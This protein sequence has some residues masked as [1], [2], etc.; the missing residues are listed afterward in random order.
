MNFA[1]G[2]GPKQQKKPY[3]LGQFVTVYGGDG[4]PTGTPNPPAVPYSPVQGTMNVSGQTWAGGIVGAAVP[5]LNLNVNGNG[6]TDISF[7]CSPGSSESIQDLQNAGYT[8]NAD[9]FFTGTANVFLQG[10]ASRMWDPD[11]YPSNLWNTISGASGTI[12]GGNASISVS[13]TGTPWPIY[14]AYRIVASGA[15]ATGILNWSIAGMFT[16]YSAMRIGF[17]AGDANGNI[18]QIS[19][20]NPTNYTVQSGQ[21]NDNDTVASGTWEYAGTNVP[22]SQTKNSA[23]YYG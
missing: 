23:D 18:G 11:D 13:P 8:I 1:E 17:N 10:T 20:Q 3:V 19:I 9:P 2:K 16:D 5:G 22:F 12:T 6:A 21:Y 14:N 15:T 4:A 7:V